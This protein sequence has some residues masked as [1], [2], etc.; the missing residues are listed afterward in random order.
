MAAGERIA[1]HLTGA[2]ETLFMPV[3]CR[4]E[5]A[6]KNKPIL[7]DKLAFE[8]AAKVDYDL[9]KLGV[10][11]NEVSHIALRARCLDLWIVDFIN[12]HKGTPVTVLHLACGLD[13][14]AHRILDAT[15]PEASIRWVD[16]D[17]PD[18]VDL[19][20]K[21]LPAPDAPNCEYQ[22]VAGSATDDAC[23]GNMPNDRPTM[24]VLE[25]LSMYLK[26]EEGKAM[27]RSLVGRFPAGEII[28][29]GLGS[30]VL[31]VQGWIPFVRK[32]GATFHWAIDDGD[33]AALAAL[34][35]RLKLKDDLIRPQMLEM[36]GNPE[37]RGTVEKVVTAI[38]LFRRMSRLVRLEF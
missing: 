20:Q 25:G 12:R 34:D 30:I 15:P 18:V 22:L 36:A 9:A 37:K 4:A 38:P 8:L 14:R 11:P 19:R 27:I 13:A 31:K 1:A 33:A 24:V 3:Y 35:P 7:G 5:D 17:L 32:T 21:V 10:R 2:Q 23:L 28:F 16:V 26:P 29:D 6:K